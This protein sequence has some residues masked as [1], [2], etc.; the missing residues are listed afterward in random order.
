M[1]F[2]CVPCTYPLETD[3]PR[4]QLLVP[5]PPCRWLQT[6]VDRLHSETGVFS[7]HPPNH[8][9]L[10]AYL[11]GQGI[12]SHQDGPIYHPGVCILSLGASAV[13][14]FRQKLP[15]GK[16]ATLLVV[17]RSSIPFK[18]ELSPHLSSWGQQNDCC[19]RI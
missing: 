8:V 17:V 9:L 16:P 6:L 4:R 14:N 5:I 19:R 12:H 2:S 7:G 13:M 1:T 15:G 3:A 10:N 11:P 18:I